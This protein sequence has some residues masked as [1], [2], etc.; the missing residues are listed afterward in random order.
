MV[1]RF[2]DG[3]GEFCGEDIQDGVPVKVR[4]RWSGITPTSARWEQAMSADG[5]A[6]WEWNWVMEF[7][8]APAAGGSEPAPVS[9]EPVQEQR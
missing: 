6:T 8:R 5:G 4:F 2:Q 9:E 3:V 1:G 7:E